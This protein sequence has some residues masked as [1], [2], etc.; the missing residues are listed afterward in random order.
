MVWALDSS[1]HDGFGFQFVFSENHLI[2]AWGAYLFKVFLLISYLFYANA[3]LDTSKYLPAWKKYNYIIVAMLLL[4][5]TFFPYVRHLFL[6]EL[7]VFAYILFMAQLV[8]QKGY[9]PARYLKFGNIIILLGFLLKII[10]NTEWINF[11]KQSYK[12]GIVIFV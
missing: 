10:N 3:F 5:G 4:I 11:T 7:L 6:S 9:R 8:Y 2:T 1:V 12:L